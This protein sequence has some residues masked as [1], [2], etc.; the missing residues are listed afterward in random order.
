MT[1]VLLYSQAVGL[2]LTCVAVEMCKVSK[3]GT[4]ACVHV[5]RGGED[6]STQVTEEVKLLVMELLLMDLPTAHHWRLV[7]TRDRL[8]NVQVCVGE[9]ANEPRLPEN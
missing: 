7:E 4:G 5:R 8:E 1:F 6:I 2:S 9:N 3:T